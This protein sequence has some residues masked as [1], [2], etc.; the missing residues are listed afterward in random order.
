MPDTQDKEN[1]NVDN[2]NDEQLK[3]HAQGMR[4]TKVSNDMLDLLQQC[5]NTG[6]CLKAPKESDILPENVIVSDNVKKLQ[7]SP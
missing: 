6:E 7:A 1:E 5:A 3:T 2:S 4:K